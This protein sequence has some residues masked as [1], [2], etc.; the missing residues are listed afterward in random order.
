MSVLG[1]VAISFIRLPESIF[2]LG[3]AEGLQCGHST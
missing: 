3:K 1:F 2:R